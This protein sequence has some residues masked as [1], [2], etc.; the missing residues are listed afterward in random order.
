MTKNDIVVDGKVVDESEFQR[1]CDRYVQQNIVCCVSSLMYDIGK[2]LEQSAEIFDFDCDE[3]YGWFSRPDYETAATNFIENADLDDL[4]TIADEHGYWDAV[5]GEV[6]GALG[7]KLLNHYKITYHDAG[8]ISGDS[9]SYEEYWAVSEA[10]AIKQFKASRFCNEDTEVTDI[11][12]DEEHEDWFETQPEAMDLL[13]EGV[14]KLVTTNQ[15]YQWVCENFNQDYDYDEVYEHWVVQ[16]QFA[17]ELRD[18]GYVVFEFGGMTVYGRMTTG[19][20]MSLDWNV[21]NAVM[22]MP[23]YAYVWGN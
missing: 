4:E 20:S 15:E 6:K 11:E 12:V 18:Q 10:D 3:A 5:V 8:D 19:Q 22:Q 13:R 9:E 21:R 2:N 1:A 7:D 14:A 23:D 17:R 16:E